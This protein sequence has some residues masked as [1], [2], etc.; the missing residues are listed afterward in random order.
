MTTKINVNWPNDQSKQ[1]KENYLSILFH[2][3]IKLMD[4]ACYSS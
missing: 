3:I 2:S 4:F 1:I